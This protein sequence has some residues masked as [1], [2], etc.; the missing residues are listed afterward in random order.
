[1]GA[2]R[3]GGVDRGLR[4]QIVVADAS[5]L[6]A[7]ADADDADHEACKAT[8]NQMQGTIIGLSPFVLAEADYLVSK[9]LGLEP[10]VALLRD[11]ERNAYRL[12]P[13]E[14]EDVGEC[15]ALIERYRDLDIGLADASIVVL[16]ARLRTDRV[17]TLDRRHF[18]ALRPLSGDR[19]EIVPKI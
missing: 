6:Y 17:F 1:M 2:R 4:Q 3:Q 8:L 16:A 5:A 11:V 13:F 18:E 19:F 15:V 12:Y 9:R 10:E 7:L 14:A